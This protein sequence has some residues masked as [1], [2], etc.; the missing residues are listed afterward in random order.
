MLDAAKAQLMPAE[1]RD[2]RRLAG[3]MLAPSTE[4]RVPGADGRDLR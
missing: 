3:V 2:F 4:Y 1:S